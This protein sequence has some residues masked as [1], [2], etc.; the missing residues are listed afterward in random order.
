MAVD[1]SGNVFVADT[2]NSAVKEIV[3]VSGVV[4]SSSTVN[5]I[6]SG[7]RYPAGVAVDGSGNVFV[8]DSDNN[9]VKEIV[10]VGG[11]VSS[12]S[13]VKTIGTG[14]ND[15]Y[16]VAVDGSG[17]VFVADYGN[18]AVK[19]IVRAPQ[20]LP[21]TA[22]GSTSTSLSVPFTFDSG[23]SIGAPVVLTQGASGRDFADAGT[24]SCTTNGT[25]HLYNAGDTCT[26]DVTFTPKYPGQRLGAVQLALYRRHGSIATAHIYGTGTGPLVTFPGNTTVNTLGSGFS[27]PR[28]VAVDGSGNVFVA[29]ATQQCGEGDC[30]GWRRGLVQLDREYGWQRHPSNGVAVDGSGNVFVADYGNNAVKEIVAVSGVVSSSS[31]V[32]TLG[33]GFSTPTGVAVDGSGNVFVADTG[34]NAVKEIVAV[35]GMVSSSS[36]VNTIGSGFSYPC[37]VAVDGS[38]NVFVADSWQQCGEGDRGGQ[39]RGLVQLDREYHRQ[40]VPLSRRRGGGRERQRLRRRL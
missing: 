19:E 16:G 36:T 24:G 31:T 15:P 34:N 26:V 1:G 35:G 30:G 21:T 13:T 40:R 18:S 3:A 5:T 28:G 25:S 33:S 38:G 10:A 37:G 9:V 32:N 11:V 29:D 22:V 20:K 14:F 6:G 27:Y 8:A 39:R 23:G 2:N 4:S 12:S 17:N 7:F